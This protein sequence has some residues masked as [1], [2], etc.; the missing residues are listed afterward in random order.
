M[1]AQTSLTKWLLLLWTD[2]KRFVNLGYLI[3]VLALTWVLFFS[4]CENII[5]LIFI[6]VVVFQV[7]RDAVIPFHTKTPKPILKRTLAHRCLI[8]VKTHPMC[9]LFRRKGFAQKSLK[10]FI[11]EILAKIFLRSICRISKCWKLRSSKVRRFPG[12]G[13][14]ISPIY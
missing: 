9:I 4:L 12:L 13:V 5:L 3:L 8:M 10:V 6:E 1:L 2:E 14:A 11:V 7:V